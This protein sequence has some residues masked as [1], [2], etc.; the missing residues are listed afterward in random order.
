MRAENAM[1]LNASTC[2]PERS[3]GR[4][5]SR[6]VSDFA[7][8]RLFAQDFRPKSRDKAFKAEILREILRPKEGLRMTL[9]LN[10]TDHQLNCTDHQQTR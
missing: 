2:H 5:I 10:C 1:E 7:T 4:R 3:F 8:S 9:P 6:D